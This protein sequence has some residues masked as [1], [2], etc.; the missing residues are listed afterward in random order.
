MPERSLIPSFTTLRFNAGHIYSEVC[1]AT[2]QDLG[3]E[4]L[5]GEELFQ[6]GETG[7]VA[8]E[9]GGH[10]YPEN[11]RQCGLQVSTQVKSMGFLNRTFDLQFTKS[12][13]YTQDF[14][15]FKNNYKQHPSWTN[16]FSEFNYLSISKII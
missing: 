2:N 10:G 14:L 5:H 4:R 16:I 11:A 7:P 9:A 12:K 15:A 3:K 1:P 8:R 6:V 13:S